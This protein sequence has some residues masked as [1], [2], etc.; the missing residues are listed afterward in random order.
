M[1][2]RQEEP[3]Q[4]QIPKRVHIPNKKRKKRTSWQ[5]MATHVRG[6]KVQTHQDDEVRYV[7]TPTK[8]NYN[9]NMNNILLWASS[10]E[11]E[12]AWANITILVSLF[13]IDWNTPG[14]TFC[15]I[16]EQLEVGS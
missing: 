12:R 2:L 1:P 6:K 15:L 14:T 16:F 11:E 4:K 3:T 13:E 7:F 8:E 10:G 9:S 5:V